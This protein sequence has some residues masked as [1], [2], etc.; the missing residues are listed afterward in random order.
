V[1]ILVCIKRKDSW[2]DRLDLRFSS[3]TLGKIV[4]FLEDRDIR[5]FVGEELQ[6]TYTVTSNEDYNSITEF[7]TA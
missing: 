6:R 5:Y 1:S 4:K 3:Y 7:L 2:I